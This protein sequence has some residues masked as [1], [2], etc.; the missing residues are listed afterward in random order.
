MN[1]L[2]VGL[3]WQTPVAVRER[4][5][6]T[7]QRRA[8][9]LC[10]LR[11]RHRDAEFALLSTCNR[12]ELFAAAADGAGAVRFEELCGFLADFQRLPLEEFHDHLYLHE[13]TGAVLHAFRVAGGL[14]SLILG[15]GQILRQVRD[16]Y[17][18]A[19]ET[20]AVGPLLHALFQKASAV[21]RRV[22]TE[23]G[24]GAGKLSIGSAAVDAIREVFD[25]FDDKTVLMVGAGKMAELTVTHLVQ[26]KPAGLL[27]CNRDPLKAAALAERFGGAPRPFEDLAGAIAEADIIVS[28][29]GATE[30][31][32]RAADFPEIMR[33]RRNRYLAIVDIAVPRDFETAVG[34]VDNVL[35]WNIDDL[36]EIGEQTQRLRRGELDHAL[37]I[38]DAEAHA[39]GRQWAARRTGPVIGALERDVA[40]MIT[41][42]LED[43]LL[44]R[45]GEVTAEQEARIRQFAHRV[46]RKFLHEPKTA[47]RTHTENGHAPHMLDAIRK[48]FNLP[49]P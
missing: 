39:F 42:E 38:V 13:G 4:L 30:P 49:D 19:V 12:T 6:F 11:R 40:D 2:N 22:Q 14:D 32:A 8:D 45:L 9:A 43:W 18:A 47:L 33:R 37:R 20:G 25:R 15:E 28:S 23:T 16:A 29:T 35:L 3:N 41:R 31:I 36:K 26:L 46:Q 27:V 7:A 10:E 21:A 5:A 17:Q 24:V 48:L 44:P 1:L 34:D